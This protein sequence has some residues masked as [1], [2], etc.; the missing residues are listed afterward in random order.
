MFKNLK[1]LLEPVNKEVA[2]FVKG[3]G[4]ASLEERTG[5]AQLVMGVHRSFV[6]LE[7]TLKNA[8]ATVTGA[9]N[10]PG[11]YPGAISSAALYTRPTATSQQRLAMA[12]RLAPPYL[13]LAED[14]PLQQQ[15]IFEAALAVPL[16]ATALTAAD[17]GDK[18]AAGPFERVAQSLAK[19]EEALANVERTAKRVL[20]HSTLGLGPGNV[21]S[22][23]GA[24]DFKAGLGAEDF[25]AG[26]GA[27]DFKAGLGAEDFKAGLGAEDFKA[28]L[29]A[30]DFK[31]GLGILPLAECAES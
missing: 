11:H 1:D 21:K 28:G 4:A 24:E 13:R 3:T 17:G 6:K 18:P 25:K 19:L 10:G 5:V 8:Q 31:A 14:L 12:V 30:E 27:E 2:E 22:G 7:Q 16:P 29:G 9:L 26:L 15:H 20:T 23:L